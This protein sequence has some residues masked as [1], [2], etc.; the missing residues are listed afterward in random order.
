M[1]C[2]AGWY[3]HPELVRD[4]S[5]TLLLPLVVLVAACRSVWVQGVIQT[6]DEKP[7]A[8]VS[9]TLQPGERPGHSLAVSSDSNGCFD[10][11]E[12]VARHQDH[13]T[14]VVDSPSYK[15]L[16]I[17]V[18]VRLENLLLVTLEP[19]TSSKP[20]AARPIHSAERYGR[21]GVPCEPEVNANSLTLH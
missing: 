20:S 6:A 1:F 11:F 10:L 15:A 4:H 12:T 9:V 2:T 21:F 5:G 8:N 3:A 14:L 18:V 19:T 17:A 7:I 16:R 13:Y